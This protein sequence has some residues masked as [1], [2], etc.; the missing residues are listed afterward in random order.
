MRDAP[1][2]PAV[3]AISKMALMR[4]GVT[5]IEFSAAYCRG[6]VMTFISREQPVAEETR[7]ASARV[8]DPLD[9]AKALAVEQHVGRERA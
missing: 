4:R 8:V 9:Q 2:A 3:A 6:N 7:H 1:S 5:V